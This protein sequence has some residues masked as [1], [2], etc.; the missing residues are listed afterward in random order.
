ML[1][2]MTCEEIHFLMHQR[3]RPIWR[4]LDY[5]KYNYEILDM[6][7]DMCLAELRRRGDTKN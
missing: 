4:R 2:N 7:Y 1:K 5:S 3:I 6:L